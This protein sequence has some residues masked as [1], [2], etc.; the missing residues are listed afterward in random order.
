[1]QE[2]D[3]N[4]T[5]NL[6]STEFPMR[7]GLPQREPA[8]LEEWEK[9]RLYDR[10]MEKNEGKPV[11]VLHDGPPY[12]NGDIH[13]GTAMNK[14]IKDIIVRYRNMAG[15]KAPFVPGW[16][17]HGLPIELKARAK[18]GVEK[19][20]QMSPAELRAICR[21]FALG[22]VDD[23]REQFKRLGILGEWDNPYLTLSP[24]FEARQVEVFGEM[25]LKGYIYK[26]LKPVYW[27]PECETALAEAEIEYSEDPC[28][29]VYVKFPV[30]DDRGILAKAG[31]DPKRTSFIIW[32]TT[33][34]TLPANTAICLGP[35]FIYNVIECD[36]EYYIMAEELYEQAMAAAG[37]TDYK[38]VATFKGAELEYI[39][40]Q[41]PFLDRESLIILGDHVTLESGTGCVHTAPG[42]GVDDFNVCKKYEDIPVVVPVDNRGRMT[43]QAGAVCAG[44]TTT[45]ANKAIAKHM[46]ATG[47]LF[48]IKKIVHQYPHCWR[49]KEPVLFRATEQW[50]CSVESFKEDAIKAIRSVKWMPA[51]G[52]ERMVSMVRERSDWCV[53]RQRLWGVPIPIF[54]CEDCKKPV[55]ERDFINAVSALFRKE[56]SDGWYKHSADEI[57]PQDAKCPYCGGVHFRKEKDIMDVWF[58]SGSSHFAVLETRPYLKWPS[59]LYMEGGDQYRGWFQSSLLTAVACKGD[60]PY[61]AVLT[62]GWTVDGEGRKMSKSLGNVIVPGQVVKEYGADILRLWVASIDYRVDVRL[63]KD[64]LKQLSE[65]YRKIRNTARFILGNISD[66]NPDTDMVPDDK[67][68]EIDRWAMMRLDRLTAQV[69]AAYESYEFHDAFHKIHN[70]CVVDLSNF[71]LDVLKDRLYVEKA[72]SLTRRAAQTVIYRLLGALTR[73]LAPILAFTAEE[74]WSFMPHGSGDDAE[75]V[76]FN[77]IPKPGFFDVDNDFLAKWERINALCSDVK[78][79]LETARTDKVIGSSLDASVTLHCKGETLDFVRSVSKILPAVLIVSQLVVAEDEGGD[80]KGDFEGLGVTVAHADGEKCARCWTYSDTVGNSSHGDLCDRCAAIVG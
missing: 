71:Y 14:I 52:E 18:A 29:S 50:F 70:F 25:A 65:A 30:A 80:F 31:V 62:H 40:A 4:N 66:F 10:L 24:E 57:L 75:S 39:K 48:A 23:Q 68:E 12:A 47:S 41:H 11:W 17:T 74:I 56:G 20:V 32:T 44:M 9:K 7:A 16:D 76:L 28:Y 61:K 49:C 3:Y 34:W 38:V 53:S 26:G 43:E 19:A 72:D 8:M 27:C 73:L 69:N 5:L 63:S 21:E 54:Y 15:Y 78:K 58:D 67:L 13:I 51:W 35:K 42:H 45:D 59:D 79:A 33:T 1:M 55:I 46:E 60:A 6:P 77:E 64:V 22:Y 2:Q 36:G 37:K